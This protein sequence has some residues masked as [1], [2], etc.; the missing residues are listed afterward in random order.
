MRIAAGLALALTFDGLLCLLSAW[1]FGE[2]LWIYP[3]AALA[4]ACVMC[5]ILHGPKLLVRKVGDI[6]E[7]PRTG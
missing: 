5:T 4:P 3:A 6:I 2:V 7:K 1:V